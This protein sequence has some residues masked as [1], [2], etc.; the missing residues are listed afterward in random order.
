MIDYIASIWEVIA[1]LL[2]KVL[3]EYSVNLGK[4]KRETEMGIL[5]KENSNES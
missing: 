2:I 5:S 1:I 4:I 3:C